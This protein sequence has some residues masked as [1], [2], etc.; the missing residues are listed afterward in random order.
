[1]DVKFN[2]IKLIKYYSVQSIPEIGHLTSGAA[3]TQVEIEPAQ[4]ILMQHNNNK[5]HLSNEKRFKNKIK[6][7]VNINRRNAGKWKLSMLI[8]KKATNVPAQA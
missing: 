7:N 3:A 1:M 4:Q 6:R 8:K 2:I 5:K